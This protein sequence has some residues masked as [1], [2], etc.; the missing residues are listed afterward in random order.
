MANEIASISN[1]FSV[2]SWQKCEVCVDTGH[3]KSPKE[4]VRHLRDFHSTKEGGSFICRYGP[5]QMCP[6]LPIE[7]VNSRDYE[8]HLLKIHLSAVTSSKLWTAEVIGCK[9][10]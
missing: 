9:C 1:K 4:F 10:N 7:G 3:F 6:K 2:P 5:H 8:D